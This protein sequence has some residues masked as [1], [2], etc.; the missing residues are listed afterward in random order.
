MNTDKHRSVRFE[1]LSLHDQQHVLN[2]LG[3]AFLYAS[4]DLIGET[5]ADIFRTWLRGNRTWRVFIP[6]SPTGGAR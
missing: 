5:P 1:D 3:I 4:G 6:D 2:L